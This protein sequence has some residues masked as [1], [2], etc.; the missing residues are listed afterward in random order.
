LAADALTTS[1][2]E[3]ELLG[4]RIAQLE[5]IAGLNADTIHNM[6]HA[7]AQIATGQWRRGR[8]SMPRGGAGNS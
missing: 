4:Q 8:E 6:Q 3:A 5:M 2:A 1:N 7:A